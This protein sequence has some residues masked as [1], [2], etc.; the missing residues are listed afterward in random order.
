M[1]W[2]LFI[3][4]NIFLDFYRLPGESAKRQL[5]LLEKHKDRL[6]MGDQVRME[7]LKNRQKVILQSINQLKAPESNQMPQVLAESN[8]AKAL[9]KTLAKAKEYSK[10]VKKRAELILSNPARYDPVFK[11]FSR[12]F[13]TSSPYNLKRPNKKRFEIRNLARK[14]FVLGYPPR[15][16]SDTSFG[17]AINWEWIINCAQVCPE[18]SN[19]ILVSRDGDFGEQLNGSWF[20]NDWLAREFKDRVSQKRKILLTGKLTDAL[21]RMDEVVEEV[22]VEAENKVIEAAASS[23]KL[24]KS[25][26]W[27]AMLGAGVTDQDRREFEDNW[28]D[29]LTQSTKE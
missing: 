28:K 2:L 29:A 19:I 3:D 18:S 5:A 7:F 12:I 23:Q 15:K 21:K 17:D 16:S 25:L 13:N 1:A 27:L 10:G 8:S 22:D 6:V 26:N 11:T 14:R 20:L 24:P 9:T 4:T